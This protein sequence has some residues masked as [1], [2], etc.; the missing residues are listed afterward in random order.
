MVFRS[1]SDRSDAR[2]C[3]HIHVIGD[4]LCWFNPLLFKVATP[5]LQQ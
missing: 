1:P 2:D 3:L 5:I 4:T